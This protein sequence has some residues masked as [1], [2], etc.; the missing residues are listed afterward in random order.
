[1][2]EAEEIKILTGNPKKAIIKLS[3]PMVVSNLVFTLYNL[4][5]GAW[6][7]GLGSD[8]LSAVGI[9]FPL[10]MIFIAL[11]MRLGICASSAISRRIGAIDKNNADNTAIHTLITG[12]AVALILTLIITQLENLLKLLGAEGNVLKLALDYSKIVV[13]GTIFLV[14]NNISTGI[15]NGEGNTKRS[16]YANVSGTL[17]NIV[18]D[19]IFIYVLDLGISG[20]AYATVLS[21]AISSIIFSYWFFAGKTF[22]NVRLESFKANRRILFDILRVGL[23]SSF[24]MLSMSVAMVFLNMII[25]RAD[26]SDGIAI[27]TSAWRVISFGFIPLFGVAGAV[28][29]VVGASFGAKNVEKL[30]TAYIHAIKL[31]A[32]IEVFI[33]FSMLIFAPKIA[34]IFT[35]SE[36][37]SEIYLELVDTMRILPAFLLFTPLGMMSVSM[38][39]GIGKGENSLAITILRTIILQLSFAYTFAFIL[40]FGFYGVLMGIV[41]GNILASVIAFT[42]GTLT[43]RKLERVLAVEV[44]T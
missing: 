3:A 19:P 36:A 43:I 40:G 25:L 41:T 1:M 9:F 29:A 20:A 8:A 39:Q 17:I 31:T 30:K 24:S 5:D 35:Y 14:F 6:V 4:A 7:A 28:T 23:P 38:F 13:A 44:R 42:W 32:L 26:G 15:L 18:L 11:S 22:V 21:M 16:M 2:K 10:F 37:S 33:V 34:L 12:F 27:F